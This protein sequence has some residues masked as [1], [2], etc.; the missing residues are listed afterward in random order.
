MGQISGYLAPTGTH[1]N[2]WCIVMRKNDSDIEIQLE[3]ARVD[4]E[5]ISNIFKLM[6]QDLI[7][8][9]KLV[10]KRVGDKSRT[11]NGRS[12][13]GKNSLTITCLAL[14][15]SSASTGRMCLECYHFTRDGMCHRIG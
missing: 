8:T 15:L 11:E 5:G 9:V 12:I 4:C 10:G 6:N 3:A 1:H 13:T 14:L 2:R 7:L